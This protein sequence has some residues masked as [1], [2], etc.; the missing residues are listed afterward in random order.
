MKFIILLL[1]FL[2]FGT[3]PFF[4][5]LISLLFVFFLLHDSYKELENGYL[6]ILQFFVIIQFIQY[7]LSL[8]IL[9]VMSMNNFFIDSYY[10]RAVSFAEIN[11]LSF[12]CLFFF[13]LG[14]L[15][16]PLNK[17]GLFFRDFIYTK[18]YNKYIFL[19]FFIIKILQYFNISA[20]AFP[21]HVM[22]DFLILYSLMNICFS[23]SLKNPFIYLLLF[24]FSS[25]LNSGMIGN[26]LSYFFL[27]IFLL[28]SLHFKSIKSKL[29][30]PIYPLYFFISL[31]TLLYFVGVL[32]TVKF[33]IRKKW[34]NEFIKSDNIFI[35]AYEDVLNNNHTTSDHFIN[36]LYR[37]NQSS[38][39]SETIKMVPN[40]VPF[41]EGKTLAKA[42]YES[43]TIRI[44]NK[45]K[46]LSGGREKFEKYTGRP[47]IG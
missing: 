9:E 32:Q 31:F 12:L 24:S 38:L 28:F 37:L 39:T 14:C 6:P 20:L 23:I 47:L 45:D 33:D 42:F 8:N 3:N 46:E 26:S 40:L 13:Y 34:D 35:L 5:L 2:V 22:N 17:R 25:D 7:S 41:E 4:S 44:F 27:F 15:S 11:S 21:L 10:L 29:S 19:F 16:V 30:N 36:L 1:S 18:D 43:F